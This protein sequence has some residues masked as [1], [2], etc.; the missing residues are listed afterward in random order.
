MLFAAVGLAQAQSTSVFRAP[1][2]SQ[3]DKANSGASLEAGSR[4]DLLFSGMKG[5]SDS[6]WVQKLLSTPGVAQWIANSLMSVEYQ[7]ALSVMADLKVGSRSQ[8]DKKRDEKELKAYFRER[9]PALTEPQ[10]E[11]LAKMFARVDD[12]VAT[13]RTMIRDLNVPD[14]V[15]LAFARAADDVRAAQVF[16]EFA[17]GIARPT[18]V[19]SMLGHFERVADMWIEG[20]KDKQ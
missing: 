12:K 3:S 4:A 15:A 9:M 5:L 8:S 19:D 11:R 2:S 6:A 20:M 7:E 10:V 14:P 17:L 16:Q 1:G 13:W 18:E